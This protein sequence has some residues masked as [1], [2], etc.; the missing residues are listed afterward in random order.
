[1]FS[2]ENTPSPLRARHFTRP[3]GAGIASP[4]NTRETQPLPGPLP[5]SSEGEVHCCHG[6]KMDCHG[7]TDTIP[8]HRVSVPVHVFAQ[9][10]PSFH[11]NGRA[12]CLRDTFR[13]T[14]FPVTRISV[15]VHVFAQ[16]SD[17]FTVPDVL[18]VDGTRSVGLRSRITGLAFPSTF[19]PS[20][21]RN[22]RAGRLRDTFPVTRISVSVYD[23]T[24]FSPSRTCWP[25]TGHVPGYPY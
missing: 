12:G 9:F 5:F 6:R 17:V 16:F 24:Q 18:A 21:H 7:R 19:S 14:S 2:Y 22:G 20:F 23:F 4:Y 8:D 25:L 3:G 13:R 11:R 10:S 1:M 15:P